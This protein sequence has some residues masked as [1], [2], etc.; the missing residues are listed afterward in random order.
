MQFLTPPIASVPSP[1]YLMY[2]SR[3]PRRCHTLSSPK[4]TSNSVS[5]ISLDSNMLTITYEHIG[6]EVHYIEHWTHGKGCG[7]W[8]QFEAWP[9]SLNVI[10]IPLASKRGWLLFEGGL[11]S[12]KYSTTFSLE[13]TLQSVNFLCYMCGK[14][15]KRLSIFGKY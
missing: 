5:V 15:W 13:S 10:E 3:E 12:K 4:S 14:N 2:Y 8:L 1:T 9:L 6:N 7:T 11:Y